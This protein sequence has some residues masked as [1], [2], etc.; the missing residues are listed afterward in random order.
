MSI[1]FG[2]RGTRAVW[3]TSHNR[4]VD[5]ANQSAAISATDLDLSSYITPSTFAVILTLMARTDTIGSGNNVNWVVKQKGVTNPTLQLTLD[6]AGVTL[7]VYHHE[8]CICGVDADGYVQYQFVHTTG[9]QNDLI[10]D[11]NG[12]IEE[13]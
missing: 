1:A 11:L 12:Y 13:I 5:L 7:G 9:W 2:T 3:K 10:I 4:V 6:K 8:E